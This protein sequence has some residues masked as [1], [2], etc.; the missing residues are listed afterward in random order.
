MSS[1]NDKSIATTTSAPSDTVN[2]TDAILKDVSQLLSL[3]F[4]TIGKSRE[5]PATLCQ[6]S[7]M[8][9]LLD[10]MNESGV[11]TEADLQQFQTR[12]NELKDIIHRAV[13]KGSDES[14]KEDKEEEDKEDNK[15]EEDTPDDK[16]ADKEKETKEKRPYRN[17]DDEEKLAPGLKR[18]LCRKL[19][20]CQRTLNT[21][22]ESLSVV[23]HELTPI[24]QRLIQIRRQLAA[25]AARPKPSKADVE[26]LQE[27][28]RKIDSKRVDGKF[29]VAGGNVP[30]GQALL[31]GLLEENFEI[32]QE[33]VARQE[34]V[35]FPLKPIYDRLSEM[36]AQLERL[37]LTHRWTLRETV[38]TV[39]NNFK[40]SA[41]ID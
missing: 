10:H 6:L 24:H 25:I 37:V 3:F 20:I 22:V 13:N 11:Y 7:I 17:E 15:K 27:E 31:A 12:L 28:L 19:E 23:S 32:V 1:I 2:R 30:D 5:A 38:C 41:F 9:Q 36:R 35:A 39:L 33:V 26:S 29:L 8:K 18:L 14:D 21:L 16:Q 40:K 34:D 4:L